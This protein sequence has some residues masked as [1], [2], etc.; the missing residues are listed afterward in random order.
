MK[1]RTI[2]FCAHANHFSE[3]DYIRDLVYSKDW[4]KLK[5][6]LRI[7]SADVHKF[8]GYM[9]NNKKEFSNYVKEYYYRFKIRTTKDLD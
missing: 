5:E 4:K 6:F 3:F 8:E 2:Y 1:N 7:Y 9:F